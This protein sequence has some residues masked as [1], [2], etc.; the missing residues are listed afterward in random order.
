MPR[1]EPPEIRTAPLTKE[2]LREAPEWG[3][4]P[5]SRKYC[6]YWEHPE[7]LVAPGK[8][9]REANIEK[10]LAWVR[11]VRAE[12]G[13]C[14]RLLYADGQA[15]GYAQYGPPSF[16]PNARSC[17]AGPVSDDAVFLACLF[18]PSRAHRGRGWGS[19]LL[20]DILR[21]LDSRGVKAVE[22]VARKG[23]AGNPSGPVE[24][25]L[26]HGFT[27]QRDDPEFPLLRLNRDH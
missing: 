24:F 22:T 6:L 20:Q 8:E 4:H 17:P 2:N 1:G 7:L 10:K 16:F 27:V 12:F 25:Y 5:W 26:R 21:E 14:G 13:E 9:N 3:A 15:V 11:R 18:F 19:L 23:N